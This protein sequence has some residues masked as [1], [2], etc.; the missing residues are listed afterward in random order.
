MHSRLICLL[1]SFSAITLQIAGQDSLHKEDENSLLW[2]IEGNGLKEP[3][4]LFGTIHLVC[5]SDFQ[6]SPAL[7]E[8]LDNVGSLFLELDLD[9]P[10]LAMK[11]FKLSVLQ[12]GSLRGKISEEDYV[13][14]KAFMQDSIGMPMLLLDRLKPFALLSLLQ[15]RL[16]PCRNPKSYEDELKS[17]AKSKGLEIYGLE[18]VED[19]FAVFDGIPDSVEMAMVMD[20][21]DSFP[22]RK[23]EFEA[24]VR[25][26]NMQDLAALNQMISSSDDFGSYGK[27]LL[28]D[29]NRRWIPIMDTA[30]RKD[31]VLFAVGAGHL[32][33]SEG[34]LRL[35]RDKGYRVIPL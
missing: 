14:L 12:E 25:S 27:L 2:R 6:I 29:R 4:Y 31:S 32:N 35:L 7:K 22:K 20:V 16:L 21:V 15:S 3:S 23:S 17:L 28:G 26:Y 11:T 1:L 33:G 18:R 9:D 19:Q 10:S 34:I 5:P 24:M 30:M 13:R 8:T